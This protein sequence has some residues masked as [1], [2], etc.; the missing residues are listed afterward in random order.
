VCRLLLRLARSQVV[1]VESKASEEPPSEWH[2]AMA[3][4]G[5][6]APDADPLKVNG[7]ILPIAWH[8]HRAAAAIGTVDEETRAGAEALGY[9]IAVLPESPGEKPPPELVELL[10]ASA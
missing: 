4:W 3:R 2:I 5:L 1:R 10:G 6:P 7:T 9:A 8:A